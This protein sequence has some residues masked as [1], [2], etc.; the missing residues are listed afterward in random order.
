MHRQQLFF[1]QLCPVNPKQVLE[2][3]WR[4]RYRLRLHT[5]AESTYVPLSLRVFGAG[6]IYNPQNAFFLQ[7][8]NL[9]ASSCHQLAVV[10]VIM[11][12]NASNKLVSRSRN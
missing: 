2:V 3:F 1:M 10:P 12:E 11:K 8:W 4:V 9:A 6:D 7:K 5:K